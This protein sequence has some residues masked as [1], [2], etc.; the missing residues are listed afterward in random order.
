MS[1]TAKNAGGAATRASGGKFLT[2]FLD[3][4]EYGIEILS[5]REIIGLLPVTPVPQTPH[6]VQGVVNLMGQV[7]PVVDLRLKFDMPGIDATDETCI[8]VVQTGGAQL[9]IIVDKVSEVLDILSQDIVDAPTLGNEIDTDYIMGV[10]KSGTRVI[11]LL[12][13]GR[14]FPTVDLESALAA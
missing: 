10:G 13:I 14:V 1:S 11:L 3:Q 8:I 4:E 5:V 2:F 12:D 7:I 9:G 6:Y